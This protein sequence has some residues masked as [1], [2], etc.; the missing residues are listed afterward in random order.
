MASSDDDERVQQLMVRLRKL[1]QQLEEEDQ[2]CCEATATC[3]YDGVRSVPYG[4]FVSL[5]PCL[6]GVFLIWSSIH[7]AA[8]ATNTWSISKVVSFTAR[9]AEL[10]RLLVLFVFVDLLSV[11]LAFAASGAIRE[12]LFQRSD[13]ACSQLTQW[14]LGGVMMTLVG[15]ALFI[16]HFVALA[17][18]VLAFPGATLTAFAHG[19]CAAGDEST[20]AIARVLGSANMVSEDALKIGLADFC[21]GDH[22]GI[23]AAVSYVSL[24]SLLLYL[25][26]VWMLTQHSG[27]MALQEMQHEIT[28]PPEKKA[29]FI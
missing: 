7:D 9:A 20:N 14:L 4:A 26:Q 29:T 17:G 23:A 24:G 19:A 5:A 15:L 18:L 11:A 13:N 27:N 22:S 8:A 10:E 12:A 16:L 1:E 28:E 21:S 3:V 6:V 25:G 2:G